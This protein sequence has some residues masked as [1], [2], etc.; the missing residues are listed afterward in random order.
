MIYMQVIPTNR[1]NI[2]VREEL[3]YWMYLT[4]RNINYCTECT[5]KYAVQINELNVLMNIHYN[6]STECT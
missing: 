1:P 3:L 4:V 2:L 6:Y 5:E